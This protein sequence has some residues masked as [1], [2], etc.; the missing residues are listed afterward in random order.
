MIRKRTVLLV[1]DN[2]DEVELALRAFES[3]QIPNRIVVARDGQDA[4]DYSFVRKPVDWNE[5]IR[6]V[7]Q[8]GSYRLVRNEAPWSWGRTGDSQGERP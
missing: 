4:L 2:R 7:Q 1:E 5:F 6:A 8:L 3:N